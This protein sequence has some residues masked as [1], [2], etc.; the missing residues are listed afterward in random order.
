MKLEKIKIQASS[1][2]A[3]GV[4]DSD[5]NCLIGVIV[6]KPLEGEGDE[7]N[8][9]ETIRDM[10][11]EH[12]NACCVDICSMEG[13]EVIKPGEFG[14]CEIYAHIFE[15]DEEGETPDLRTYEICS[16]AAY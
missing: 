9:T 7:I 8:V 6:K 5:D 3:Y 4:W 1:S 12:N 2:T 14:K 16:I 10:I 13:D 15:S 11:R